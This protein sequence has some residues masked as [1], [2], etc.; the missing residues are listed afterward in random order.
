MKKI[1]TINPGAT[2]TKVAYFEDE[3]L[4][5][6]EEITYSSEINRFEHVFDQFDMRYEDLKQLLSEHHIEDIDVAVGRGGLIGPV[7]SGGIEVTEK[8]IH[9]LQYDPVLEHPSN[10]GSKLAYEVAKNFGKKDAK[11]YIYDPVTVDAMSDV[12]RL[13]GLKEVQRTSIGHHLNMRAVAMKAA[14]DLNR[15]YEDIN[16]IVVHL[17]GGAS[18]SAH[19]KGEIV[20]FVSD[21]EIMFSAERSG[22]LPIKEALKLLKHMSLEAFN[23]LVRKEAGLQSHCGTKDLK[24]IGNRIE[25]GDAYA[26]LVIEAMALGVAKCIASLSATLKGDVDAICV[27]GGMVHYPLLRE[28]I[29]ARVK[30]IGE[31]IA[32][33]GEFEMEALAMGGL[34]IINQQEAVNTF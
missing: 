3:S 15:F 31:L 28:E 24:E 20:D 19:E 30:F 17:G 7:K 22:G 14:K 33:P 29:E 23:T 6:K 25:N 18:A 1:V 10:L 11:A 12:A 8:L 2:S 9:K 16:V 13:T 26:R 5:W 34:R 4:K 21:D 32:Y 27:T